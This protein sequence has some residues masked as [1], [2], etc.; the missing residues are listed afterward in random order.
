[1]LN[2][3]LLAAV[4]S[5]TARFLPSNR[6]SVPYYDPNANGGSMLNNALD[7]YG[8][9]LNVIIS[10]LSSPEV[11]QYEGFYNYAQAIGFSEECFGIHLGDPFSA[12]LGDGNGWVNQTVE[13]RQDY[14]LPDIG[15]CLESLIGG[16]HFRLYIQ[17]GPAADS[18]ALFLAVSK[19][20]PLS[21]QHN[22]VPDGYNIGR[23]LL[24]ASAIGVTSYN[25][26]IYS[27]VG[28]KVTG[29]L[30][31]GSVGVNHNI[32]TDGYTTVLTVTIVPTWWFYAQ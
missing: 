4:A 3:V 20:E 17:N 27:T 19:E 30:P 24:S 8:E 10:A 32:S 15:T 26:I 21:E 29:L 7:G 23:D 13:L 1:M 22:V 16:N 31:A 12:N 5:A 9:P 14:D 28:V 6:L 2:F 18:G 11:L 25:G